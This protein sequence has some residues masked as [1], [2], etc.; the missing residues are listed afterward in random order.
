MSG[1]ASGVADPVRVGLIGFGFA[2]RTFHGP[3]I[4]ALP[5]LELVSV[6]TTQPDEARSRH[7][8][9]RVAASP[10]ELIDDPAV[11]LVVV[12][13]PNVLHAPLARRALDRGRHV[14]VEKPFSL[15]LAEAR[16]VLD[17]AAAAD[18]R[19]A[20]FHN[21]R[22]D[23]DFLT[24]RDAIRRGEIGRVAEVRSHFDRFRPVVRD[25][26]RER[27]T[28]GGGIWL[29][30]G[31]HL[32][33]QA[34]Q[35]FGL[36]DTVSADIG[37]LRAGAPVDDWFEVVLGYP[38]LRVALHATMLAAGGAPR[39]TLH[40]DRGSL[41]KAGADR[42]EAQLLQGARP[43]C[44]D[45]GADPDPLLLWD[46]DGVRREVPA[47]RG[48]QCELYRQLAAAIRTGTPNPTPPSDVLAVMTVLDAARR[49]AREGRVVALD[50]RAGTGTV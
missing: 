50:Q 30:L 5:E 39:F 40:G 26:W 14:L 19:L 29:D 32:A 18:R 34:L 11:E 13:T 20:V 36:P 10:D 22:W 48:D 46:E 3:M 9:A 42:Q 38:G 24:V 37:V 35:L 15:D 33:D 2:G 41:V 7:P 49:S 16:T 45:W 25:R 27:D 31:P 12:A 28:P 4:E 21:R 44:A 43:G 1:A 23:S 8:G 17:A 6:C 47:L